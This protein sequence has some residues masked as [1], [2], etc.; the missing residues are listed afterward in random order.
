MTGIFL[1]YSKNGQ[2]NPI[3][4]EKN[5][6]LLSHRGKMNE[7]RFIRLNLYLKTFVNKA[8]K[9]NTNVA[10]S[11]TDGALELGYSVIDGKI[12]N[13]TEFRKSL[14]PQIPVSV[15]INTAVFLGYSHL[16]NE[17][18][19]KIQ[20]MYSIMIV[21]EQGIVIAKDPV[22]F[23]PLYVVN[24][25]DFLI[26]TSELKALKGFEGTPKILD[27]GFVYRYDFKTQTAE[28]SAFFPTVN[29]TKGRS[30]DKEDVEAI[31][32]RI[33]NMLD[34]IVAK[35]IDVCCPVASLLSGGI[36]SAII[37]AI[38]QKYIP[39]LRV[40]TVAAEGSLDLK[41]AI[42]FVKKYPKLKHTVFN[43]T[44]NDLISVVKDVI[45]HLETFDAALI[46]SA[47]PMYY[48]CSKIDKDI[49]EIGR[50]SCRERV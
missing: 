20:G 23:N 28:Y 1:Y 37:C 17:L 10:V 22:G 9:N 32:S 34:N 39:D 30:L 40:Y 44:L 19:T 14:P 47:L 25:D 45:F 42:E 24:T 15:D 7:S 13:E 48:L 6:D 12:L 31:K 4:L 46:R 38:A 33:F 26:I 3:E 41:H 11:I 36:D 18:F 49:G 50:A 35:N 43:V 8:Q 27:P 5:A 2:F 16:G 21:N 29:F